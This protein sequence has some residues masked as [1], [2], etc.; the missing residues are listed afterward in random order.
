MQSR[1]KREGR[2]AGYAGGHRRINWPGKVFQWPS[3]VLARLVMPD[4]EYERLQARLM[5]KTY[6]EKYKP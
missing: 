3:S 4:A 2:Y 1:N 6:F 5:R